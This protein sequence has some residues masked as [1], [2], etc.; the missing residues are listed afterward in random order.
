MIYFY[1]KKKNCGYRCQ[2]EFMGHST[3]TV[4]WAVFKVAPSPVSQAKQF[5]TLCHMPNRSE[6]T[7]YSSLFQRI[8]VGPIQ[9]EYVLQTQDSSFSWGVMEPF[10]YGAVQL[11]RAKRRQPITVAALFPVHEHVTL[12]IS[13]T[14]CTICCQSIPRRM[15]WSFLFPHAKRWEWENRIIKSFVFGA[16]SKVSETSTLGFPL[17]CCLQL[18]VNAN[19]FQLGFD[20]ST[21]WC[22]WKNNGLLNSAGTHRSIDTFNFAFTRHRIVTWNKGR[23]AVRY[24]NWNRINM[25][26]NVGSGS[27][28]H[29]I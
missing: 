28:T 20:R 14:Q 11:H 23:S 26:K 15:F 7:C 19:C 16:R 13:Y 21:S 8:D 12:I 24:K 22:S 9:Y 1:R 2:L 29:P 4:H 25:L 10:L 6:Y 3:F 27:N 18:S 5:C 17:S